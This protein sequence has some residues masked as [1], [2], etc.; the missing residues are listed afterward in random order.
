MEWIEEWLHVS[1]DGGNGTLE[2]L[3]LL[4]PVFS[5]AAGWVAVKRF[6]RTGRGSRRPRQTDVRRNDGPP[7]EES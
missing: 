4:V 6:A 5:L 3:F 1:P 2:L 7:S